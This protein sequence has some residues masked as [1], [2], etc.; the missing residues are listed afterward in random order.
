MI[1]RVGSTV[2]GE[3]VVIGICRVL[4]PP[5]APPLIKGAKQRGPQPPLVFLHRL[6]VFRLQTVVR[7]FTLRFT[8]HFTRRL[9]VARRFILIVKH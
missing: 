8:L 2:L 4:N 7:R 9:F 6:H 3:S 5:H 1:Y